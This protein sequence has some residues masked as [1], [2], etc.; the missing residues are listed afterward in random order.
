MAQGGDG[1]RR[2]IAEGEALSG[3]TEET[4]RD[5]GKFNDEIDKLTTRLGALALNIAGPILKVF[6]EFIDELNEGTKAAGGFWKAIGMFGTTNPFATLEESV[7]KYKK[8]VEELTEKQQKYGELA[9]LAFGTNEKLATA[10]QRLTY[11][12]SMLAIE[13]RKSSAAM[14]EGASGA[15]SHVLAYNAMIASADELL[16]QMMLEFA[17]IGSTNEERQVSI[18]LR[19][20]EEIGIRKGTEA[21]QTYSKEIIEIQKNSGIKREMIRL[22]EEA[23]KNAKRESEEYD[24]L[25]KSFQQQIAKMQIENETY[26]AGNAARERAIFLRE[27]ENLKIE[28]RSRLLAQYDE[29]AAIKDA[30]EQR[31]KGVEKQLEQQ[32]DYAKEMEKIND[33]IGQSLTDALMNGGMNARDFIVNLFKT[34]ILRPVLQPIIGAVTGA[35]TSLFAGSALAGGTGAGGASSM[36]QAGSLISLVG[37]AKT[38]YQVVT[39]GFAS[40]GTAASNLAATFMGQNLAV[41]AALI[42]SG[43]IGTAGAALE[44][45]ALATSQLASSIG[46]FSQYAAGIS[47]GVMAGQMISGNY[48]VGGSSYLA[49]GGGAIIGAIVGGPLGAAIGGAIGGVINRAFGMAPKETKSAGFDLTLSAAGAITTGFEKWEQKGGWFRSS[50]S[51]KEITAVAQETIDFFNNSALAV[52][53][54]VAGMSKMFGASLDNINDFSLDIVIET[55]G[56]TKEQI[57]EQIGGAF[58]YMETSLVDFLIPNIYEFATAADKTAS[59]I[60][61]R[62]VSSIT[63]VNQAFEVLGYNLYEVS[64]QGANTA[65]KLVD[66]FGGIENFS[67]STSF[68]YENFYTAQEKV[69]FQTEQL[70]KVFDSLG[71]ALP[72]TNA[73]FRQMVETAQAAGNDQ[74]FAT[75]VQ[76]APAFNTL[77]VAMEQTTSSIVQQKNQLASQI[78][79]LIGDETS[80]REE[81]RNAID[82]SNLALFDHMN[83]IKDAQEVLNAANDAAEKALSDLQNAIE[84]E[85]KNIQESI[86]NKLAA[87]LESLQNKFDS[88]TENINKQI[89]ALEVQK[90]VASEALGGLQSIFGF[91][92]EQVRDILGI[93]EP[94][95]IA[96]QGMAFVAQAVRNAQS[97]GYLPDPDQL[98]QAVSAARTGLGGESFSSAFEM[99][100][101]NLQFANQLTKLSE[102]AATQITNAEEQVQKADEQIELLKLQLEQAR[103]QY[104]QNVINER[105]FYNAQLTSQQQQLN[106]LLGINSGVLS[107]SSATR[108]LSI[109]L[110]AQ[111]AASAALAQSQQQ[112]AAAAAT[113]TTTPA[114]TPFEKSVNDIYQKRL[115]RPVDVAGLQYWKSTNQSL[116]SI[117]SDIML[118]SEYRKIQ[119]EKMYKDILGREADAAGLAYWMNDNSTLEQIRQNLMLAK[120]A[121][122][123]AEGGF[124]P[125]GMALVGEQG[126]E[127]I[128]FKRPGQVYTASET[129]SIMSGGNESNLEIRQLREE[130]RAQSRAMVGLQARMTRILEQWD[131]DGIPTER[132]EGATA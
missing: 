125:G 11:F 72:S 95:Q 112:A 17:L 100:K 51:G 78:Y 93:M 46:I 105:N 43:T 76:L 19:K 89:Q 108:A 33:Q 31:K 7:A 1:L 98:R 61:K 130:N 109:A 56:A 120:A 91:L 30:N 21:F 59:D 39:N 113:A 96:A 75:L 3:V 117:E 80:L 123:F 58:K 5:A 87:A 70:T 102:V 94:T 52:S 97:S 64:L 84:E 81:E 16:D 24:R 77:Q 47:A 90:Q 23:A 124:Y 101:A 57:E 62:L 66:L 83:A 40:I 86:E 111:S 116:A 34:M 127:L 9:A 74:L 99:R 69:N 44:A 8:E 55:L 54:S 79:Q 48:K 37:A 106:A 4:A 128:N 14:A 82:A 65:S 28:D 18:A 63:T 38:A 107:L 119:I 13:K 131:G 73:A 121:G 32:K 92:R 42:E 45:N 50:K 2:L 53:S 118:G 85:S 15:N 68:Y 132:Y 27:T 35:V 60:L 88:L 20:L 22:S 104:D 26:F 29:A 49:T 12:E 103:Q 25:V 71:Y 67:K 114:M 110:N 6:S 41:N 126:P 10:T 129:Q 36:S 122:Q 115:E